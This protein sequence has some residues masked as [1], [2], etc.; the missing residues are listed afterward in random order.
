MFFK[1]KNKN[2][3][4]VRSGILGVAVGDALGVLFEFKKRYSYNFNSKNNMQG[5]L[6]HNQIPGTWSDDTSLTLATL[7]S[8]INHFDSVQKHY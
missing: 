4:I 6:S 5:F 7:D 3:N 8:L 2:Y 1:N